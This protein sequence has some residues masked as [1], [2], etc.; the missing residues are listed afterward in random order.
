MHLHVRNHT[1]WNSHGFV[2]GTTVVWSD[3]KTHG[4][5]PR[6]HLHEDGSVDTKDSKTIGSAG[7]PLPPKLPHPTRHRHF[8]TPPSGPELLTPRE[9]TAP[10]GSPF[11]RPPVTHGPRPRRW[12]PVEGQEL[13]EGL[14]LRTTARPRQGAQEHPQPIGAS[15]MFQNTKE[16]A[17]GK[18]REILRELG[19][20]RQIPFWS[21][22][23]SVS[24]S[25]FSE[26]GCDMM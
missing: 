20:C 12:S 6:F 14:Q 17:K 4:P 19:G 15:K 8:P 21:P 23:V 22:G 3:R 13:F 24:V 26:K 25:L 1:P 7:S 9:R 18:G 2:H 11:R 5:S 16:G 10:D